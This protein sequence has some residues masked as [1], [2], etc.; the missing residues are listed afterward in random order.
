MAKL[1]KT[2][3]QEQA[4]KEIDDKI[5]LLKSYESVVEKPFSP[6]ITLHTDAQ[7]EKTRAIN[8]TLTADKTKK[9]LMEACQQIASQITAATSKFSLELDDKEQQLVDSFR[10]GKKPQQEAE[11]E[12]VTEEEEPDPLYDDGSG[13]D[14]AEEETT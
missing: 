3:Q 12:Q 9:L 14:S 11:A 13:T 5:K 10:S 4:L 6:V 7:G 2:A 1:K 8:L